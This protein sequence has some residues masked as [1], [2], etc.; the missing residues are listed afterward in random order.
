MSGAK[1]TI[2]VARR[3]VLE[4]WKNLIDDD[5]AIVTSAT[6]PEYYVSI[7]S[8]VDKDLLEPGASIL[9]HHK[10]CLWSAC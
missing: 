1:W 3:W 5:H 8:F 9:L 10:P 6:G 7:M 4:T 2:C